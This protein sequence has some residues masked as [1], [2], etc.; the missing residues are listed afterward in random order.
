ML[1]RIEIIITEYFIENKIFI[2][3]TSNINLINHIVH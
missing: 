3:F 2:F 1:Y